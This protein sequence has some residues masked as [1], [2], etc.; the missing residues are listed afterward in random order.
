[1]SQVQVIYTSHRY[2]GTAAEFFFF[3]MDGQH[4]GVGQFWY[5][6]MVGHTGNKPKMQAQQYRSGSD[7]FLPMFTLDTFVYY[8]AGAITIAKFIFSQKPD[9]RRF[10]EVIEDE[11]PTKLY[12]DIDVGKDKLGAFDAGAYQAF[13]SALLPKI[14][15]R[16]VA[17]CFGEQL[18]KD[19]APIV[20]DATVGGKK[21]SRHIIFNDVVM[22]DVQHVKAFMDVLYPMVPE[23]MRGYID[24]SIYH[25]G[26]NFRLF[27]NTKR[28]KKNWLTWVGTKPTEFRPTLLLCSS[29][30]VGMRFIENVPDWHQDKPIIEALPYVRRI[31]SS[32]SARA[33]I[34]PKRP[35]R[36]VGSAACPP[37]WQAAFE[38]ISSI[39]RARYPGQGYDFQYL[40][41]PPNN[42]PFF[43]FR[44][45]NGVVCCPK[46]GRPHKSNGCWIK[47]RL[48]TGEMYYKCADAECGYYKFN[49]EK[50]GDFKSCD[51][52]VNNNTKAKRRRMNI[53]ELM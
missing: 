12:I 32:E 24:M 23:N 40:V 36:V 43:E 10:F 22:E 45:G 21:F 27:G 16:C 50:I 53:G 49:R 34:R 15:R 30:Q 52:R 14:V 46:I 42:T 47:V 31:F 18:P 51:A 29:V 20:L 26:R 3:N 35:F 11:R 6:R 2:P 38:Q 37:K 7:F 25:N 19:P 9:S 48:D 17:Q 39:V 41:V 8:V 5:H 4:S 44:L 28:G 1:M 13:E 33:S